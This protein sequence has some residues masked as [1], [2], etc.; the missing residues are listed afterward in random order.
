MGVI[1]PTTMHGFKAIR[2]IWDSLD[3]I[4]PSPGGITPEQWKQTATLCPLDWPTNYSLCDSGISLR[5][6]TSLLTCCTSNWT[7]DTCLRNGPWIS[8]NGRGAGDFPQLRLTIE[9][10]EPNPAK[11]RIARGKSSPLRSETR[12]GGGERERGGGGVVYAI[13]S[14]VLFW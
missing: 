3:V 1:E 13:R 11:S 12:Q 14:I 5:A 7:I 6:C 4:I 10:E 2:P 9:T 8:K